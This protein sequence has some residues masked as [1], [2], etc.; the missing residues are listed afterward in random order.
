V[1]KKRPYSDDRLDDRGEADLR[2]WVI[3]DD[4]DDDDDKP[5]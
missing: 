4:D 5:P 3:L 2:E 1:K